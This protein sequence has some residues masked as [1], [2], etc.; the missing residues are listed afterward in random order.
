VKLV[1]ASGSDSGFRDSFRMEP[2]VRQK[3]F[4][5]GFAVPACGL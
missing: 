2:I 5:N 1:R 3:V 4:V